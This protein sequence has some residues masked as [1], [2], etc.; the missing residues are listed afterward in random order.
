MPE[1]ELSKKCD[2]KYATQAVESSVF[3]MYQQRH[4]AV[5][6]TTTLGFHPQG[7]V[8]MAESF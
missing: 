1:I 4:L 6:D 5:A 3:K 8:K 7:T 2:T